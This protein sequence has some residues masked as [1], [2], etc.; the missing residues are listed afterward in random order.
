MLNFSNLKVTKVSIF[1]NHS[2]CEDAVNFVNVSGNIETISISNSFSDA[3][4][5]D[6]SQVKINTININSA[7]ND[8]TDFSQVFII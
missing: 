6:F 8:C 7:V 1:S 2:S 3:L 4:D 5:I